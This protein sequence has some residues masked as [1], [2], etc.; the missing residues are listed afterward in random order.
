MSRCREAMSSREFLNCPVLFSL[1]LCPAQGPFKFFKKVFL[2]MC[3]LLQTSTSGFAQGDLS[4]QILLIFLIHTRKE[5]MANGNLSRKNSS[6]NLKIKAYISL[7][8]KV[9]IHP[10][11]DNLKRG[12]VSGND[13]KG[14]DTT[15]DDDDEDDDD[16]NDDDRSHSGTR[17]LIFAPIIHHNTTI[18]ASCSD[19]LRQNRYVY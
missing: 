11:N 3:H 13:D 5:K 16:D 4:R 1:L 19:I 14:R 9:L 15:D 7:S 10:V 18:G 2:V 12:C 6:Y 17:R 8:K